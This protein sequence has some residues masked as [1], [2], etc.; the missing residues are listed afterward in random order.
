MQLFKMIN[1][2]HKFML[3]K[4]VFVAWKV[5]WKSEWKSQMSAQRIKKPSV[6]DFN[7]AIFVSSSFVLVKCFLENLS[8]I[9][10]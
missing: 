7:S 1:F 2:V 10:N 9:S 3:G 8:Q 6:D 5:M 4:Y